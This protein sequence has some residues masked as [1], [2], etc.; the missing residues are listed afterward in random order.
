MRSQPPP[1]ERYDISPPEGFHV[2]WY[3]PDPENAALSNERSKC[4]RPGC[5]WPAVWKFR[6]SNGWWHYCADHHYGRRIENNKLLAWRW[7]RDIDG[8]REGAGR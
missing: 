4:R 3:E 2:E 1:D 6:R 7:V 5:Q 8:E